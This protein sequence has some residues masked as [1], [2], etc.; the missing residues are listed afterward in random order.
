MTALQPVGELDRRTYL[1]GADIAAILGVSPYR[2]RLDL[3]LD[4]VEG[5]Q[6]VTDPAK[7]KILERGK[8][9][10]PYVLDMLSAEHGVQ[11]V[12]RNNRYLH[13]DYSFIAA[14]IDAE[15]SDGRN[16]E[17]KTASDFYSR[18]MWGEAGTD[19]IPVYYTAQCMHGMMVRPAPSTLLPVML[20]ID[21]FRVYN[22]ER[23]DQLIE[24]IRQAEVDFWGMIQ[25]REPPAPTTESDLLRLFPAHDTEM[26]QASDEVFR[27]YQKL[28][29]LLK[30]QK[31]LESDIEDLQL[32]L[33]MVMQDAGALKFGAN[34]LATWRK[35]DTK[36][37]DIDS[38]RTKYP[39]LAERYTKTTSSRVFRT[40]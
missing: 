9:L 7:Q 4:K 28:K 12:A 23:D 20:G 19:E 37:F 1:G 8:R 5:S 16:V 34:M 39:A 3:Y 21:D 18:R 13:P 40:R 38:F 27:K 24:E 11:I 26:V 22:V 10:E 29:D 6:P 32:E 14:E 17:A 30:R 25:R 33:K 2:T 35:Q 36:R 15:T 31:M